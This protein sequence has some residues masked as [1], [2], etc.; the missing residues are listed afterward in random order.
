[1]ASDKLK[2]FL[3]WETL[4]DPQDRWFVEGRSN[5]AGR[6]DCHWMVTR[7]LRE[8]RFLLAAVPSLPDATA[9]IKAT[10]LFSIRPTPQIYPRALRTFSPQSLS[11]MCQCSVAVSDGR[12][13]TRTPED[14]THISTD[15]P[16]LSPNGSLFLQDDFRHRALDVSNDRR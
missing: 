3:G 7:H 9:G 16:I 10:P 12:E 4:V 15:R 2:N 1:M 11:G 5:V 8:V 6:L 14:C 13:V